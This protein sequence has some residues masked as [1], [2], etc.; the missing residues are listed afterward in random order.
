MTFA[1]YIVL[2]LGVFIALLNILPTAA[3]LGFS[4]TPAVITIVGYM[5]AWDFMFPIHELFA[6]V[7]LYILT[8]DIP[9]WTWQISWKII[10][11]L[12]GHSDG[13]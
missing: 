1:I 4:F 12:R 6:L 8:I 2:I 7:I 9:L 3:S 5:K 10:K 11:F 13:A